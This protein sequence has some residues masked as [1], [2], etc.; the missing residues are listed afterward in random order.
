MS[1][2]YRHLHRPFVVSVPPLFKKEKKERKRAEEKE[3]REKRKRG[4]RGKEK[5]EDKNRP[6]REK[7][8]TS[9]NAMTSWWLARFNLWRS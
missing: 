7:Q 5:R 8:R 1:D 3:K 2:F 6:H 9:P 4:K